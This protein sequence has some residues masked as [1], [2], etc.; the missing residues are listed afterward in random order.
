MH[1]AGR[2]EWSTELTEG[3]FLKKSEVALK[4][5]IPSDQTHTIVIIMKEVSDCPGFSTISST[6]HINGVTLFILQKY[7]QGINVNEVVLKMGV[8]GI[9]RQK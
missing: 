4:S 1:T 2:T 5:K 9:F 3:K 7:L 6:F 8:N